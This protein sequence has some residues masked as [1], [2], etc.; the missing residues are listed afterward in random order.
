VG[1]ALAAIDDDGEEDE[2]VQKKQKL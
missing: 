1:T 2:R